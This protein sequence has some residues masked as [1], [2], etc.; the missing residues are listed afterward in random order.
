M[1]RLT[2]VARLTTLVVIAGAAPV[3]AQPLWSVRAEAGQ[4]AIHDN[5]ETAPAV[6]V[7]FA[8]QPKAASPV[9][10]AFG[11]AA[12]G[13]D[14]GFLGFDVSGEFVALP[15]RVIRP[16][17]GIGVGGLH[18]SDWSGPWVHL[19]AALEVRVSSRIRLRASKTWG[20]HEESDGP[21]FNMIG[22]SIGR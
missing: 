4:S 17:V 16:V 21:N 1:L 10:F 7:H 14:D 11:A 5:P 6:S 15:T 19:S 18:E 8:R 3:S 13:A 22:L 9:R 20:A 12:G 2:M